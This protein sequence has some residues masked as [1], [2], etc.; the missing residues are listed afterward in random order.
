MRR[1]VVDV[2]TNPFAQGHLYV[3][4]GRVN[5][6]NTIRVWTSPDKVCDN[7]RALTKKDVWPEIL[8]ESLFISTYLIIR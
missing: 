1:C 4:L 3:A 2:R 7:G 8:L 6:R 5:Q